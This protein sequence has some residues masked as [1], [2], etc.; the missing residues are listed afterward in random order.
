MPA[1]LRFCRNC[2]FRLGE[3]SAEY[4]QT[5]RFDGEAPGVPARASTSARVKR[6][7]RKMGGMAWIFV[8]LLAFFVCAAAFTAVISPMK[9]RVAVVQQQMNK[10]YAGV[11]EFENSDAGVTFTR[12]NPPDG[13]ADKAGLIGGD[14]IVSFDGQRIENEDQLTNLMTHTPPGKTVDVVYKRDG[15]TKTTKL[16]TV[17]R[18]DIQRLN[19][20][21]RAR[22]EGR[23]QFGFDDD[24]TEIV[25]VPGTK[26]H[27]VRLDT[28]YQNR[29]ADMAGL[30]KGDVV[31]EFGGV[32]IRTA[33]ELV[34]R[35]QRAAPYSTVK[36][37]V[38]R[39]G[40]K[41]EIPV[42]MGKQ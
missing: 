12:V 27:G 42:K 28:I 4:T 21:F 14:V 33:A 37:V 19:E 23:G 11:D 34:M 16:T 20:A 35:V 3:G 24:D 26:I 32:P 8:G 41:L 9:H 5:M 25:E 22:P 1:E 10:S 39:G 29:P 17:S 31:I 6:G 7:R 18:D 38:M 40:E 36:V 2:G 30:K 13:P 15:E